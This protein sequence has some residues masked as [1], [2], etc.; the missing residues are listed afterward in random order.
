M[1]DVT[2]HPAGKTVSVPAGSSLRD[3]AALAGIPTEIPCGGK[4]VCGKCLVRIQSGAV[5]FDGGWLIGETLAAQGYVMLCTARLKNEDVSVL[6]LQSI[7]AEAGQFTDQLSDYAKVDPTLL[8]AGPADFIVKPVQ[9]CVSAPKPGDGLSDLDRLM[10]ATRKTLG[11]PVFVPLGVLRRLP[12]A[13]REGTGDITLFYHSREDT[14]EITAT[15]ICGPESR[16]FAVAVDLGTTTVTASVCGEDGVLLALRTAYNTQMERGL[17]VISRINYAGRPERLAELRNRALATVNGLIQEL[18]RTVGSDTDDIRNISLSGNTVMIHLL[19]R[20]P[21]EYIRLDPYTPAVYR[22]PFYTAARIGL[23]ISPETPVDIAPSVGSYLGGDITSGALCTV[24]AADSEQLC[25]FIDIGT[26]GEI[27]LGNRDFLLG[28][29]C[30]AG[31]AFE[32]GGISCG[33]RASAGA[34]ERVSIDRSSG[35]VRLSV[36]GG[37]APAGICGSGMISLIAELFRAGWIDATGKFVRNRSARIIE[38]GKAAV[39]MLSDDGA[40]RE[41]TVGESDIGNIIRAKAAIFAACQTMLKSAEM[42]FSDINQVYIA[43]GFGRYLDIDDAREIGLLPSL[44]R[45]R[46]AFI[47]NASLMGTHMSL[48]SKRHRQTRER[49]ANAVTYLDLGAE[50]GYMDEYIAALFLPHTDYEQFLSAL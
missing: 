10:A 38:N 22:V 9:I 8:P 14:G 26:N 24:L 40:E 23:D 6:S 4:G 39:F 42:T 37:E 29:A 25:L 46:F 34:I 12:E 17:D 33:M 32:G 50:P 45:E 47:G 20:I 7:E 30:S 19:L 16:K 27:L 3:A 18:A 49:L 15:D 36:I 11:G 21:P 1:I 48:I 43:G 41:I 13:L 28:C 31:P 44:P 2:F 35:G 5:D